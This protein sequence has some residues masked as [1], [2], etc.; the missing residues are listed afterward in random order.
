M[1]KKQKKSGK[2]NRQIMGEPTS[3]VNFPLLPNSYHVKLEYQE[4]YLTDNSTAGA[5]EKW[6]LNHWAGRT[7][8]YGSTFYQLYKY[9]QVLRVEYT[10]R[11]SST[12]S[13]PFEA[14]LV[15]AP[16]QSSTT[17]QVLAAYRGRKLQTSSG[18]NS[19]NRILLRGSYIPSQVEGIDTTY[20]KNTWYIESDMNATAPQDIN[21]HGVWMAVRPVDTSTTGS[22]AVQVSIRYHCH[23]FAPVNTVLSLLQEEEFFEGPP[24][25]PVGP[26][27]VGRS[28]PAPKMLK[29]V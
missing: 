2:K 4:E 23:F 10:Y 25:M 15:P 5:S 3:R 7:P 14:V 9:C 16:Y 6:G 11:L 1:Q 22:Y 17:F 21:T 18:T 24:L 20:D 28:Q 19:I 29:K 27:S 12:V 8:G 13:A 26:T